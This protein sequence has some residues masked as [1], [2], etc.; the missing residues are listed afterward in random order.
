[1]S[2]KT[3]ETPS[4]Q[5]SRARAKD[6][7]VREKG[8]RVSEKL[9]N[10]TLVHVELPESYS[11]EFLLQMRQL[12][13]KELSLGADAWAPPKVERMRA[14]QGV[15]IAPDEA[16]EEPNE[17]GE[18]AQPEV[19][20]PEAVVENSTTL[21][22]HGIPS[23]VSCGKLSRKVNNIGFQGCC[24]IIH[25][26]DGVA[27]AT[28]NFR[29]P[30]ACERFVDHVHGSEARKVLGR[31]CG[32]DILRVEYAPFQGREACLAKFGTKSVARELV[33]F[34]TQGFP[35][36]GSPDRTTSLRADAPD[37]VPFSLPS[38]AASSPNLMPVDGGWA[39]PDVSIWGEGTMVMCD[40]SN[41]L[42]SDDAGQMPAEMQVAGAAH[43]VAMLSA[44]RFAEAEAAKYQTSTVEAKKAEATDI[45]DTSKDGHAMNDSRKKEVLDQV[46][47]Y[48][49]AA[50]VAQDTYLRSLMDEDGWV[51]L[52]ALVQFPRL[53]KL[54]ATAE[55]TPDALLCSSEVEVS[56]ARTHLRQ[57]QSP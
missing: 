45:V 22:I 9:G 19:V 43:I 26:P 14:V 34:D 2:E 27:S 33:F 13:L 38:T 35:V 10:E 7:T 25:F 49:S 4:P 17:S 12:F 11:A 23:G 21:I 57:R 46:E 39:V 5:R 29:T 6:G 30:E 8:Y 56:P 28:I 50:N 32:P 20:I 41:P 18:G 36:Q 16:A 3:Q 52:Q 31:R 55:N 51:D 44:Q 15:R 24:D 37:F 48:F 40:P 1:M 54:G 53:Q 42:C 47:Y